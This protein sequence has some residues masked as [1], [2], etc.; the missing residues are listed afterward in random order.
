VPSS[1]NCPET[2]AMDGVETG[3]TNSSSSPAAHRHRSVRCLG[4]GAQQGRPCVDTDRIPLHR[5]HVVLHRPRPWRTRRRLPRCRVFLGILDPLS[6]PI[7]GLCHGV[8]VSAAAPIVSLYRHWLTLLLPC[9]QLRI[10]MAGRPT[11]GS[12]C[13]VNNDNV[14]ESRHKQSHLRNHLPPSHHHHQPLR[15]QRLR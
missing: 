13:C 12:H 10:T 9:S 2:K 11:P 7:M 6:G 15:C 4:F 1:Q 14:L 8:E 5:H 3:L